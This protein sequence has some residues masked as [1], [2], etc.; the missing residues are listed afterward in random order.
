MT[1]YILG[2]CR[3]QNGDVVTAQKTYRRYEDP[4]QYELKTVS[5]KTFRNEASL[6]RAYNLLS[7]NSRKIIKGESTDEQEQHDT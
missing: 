6:T 5:V 7:P 2:Q 3:M 4:P 1:T